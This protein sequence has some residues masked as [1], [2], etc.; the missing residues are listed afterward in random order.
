MASGLGDTSVPPSLQ[1][2]F[3][4]S[5]SFGNHMDMQGV[6]GATSNQFTA[7]QSANVR[8]APFEF[9][10]SAATVQNNLDPPGSDTSWGI[11]AVNSAHP[12]TRSASR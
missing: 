7:V 12:L 9:D 2:G 4:F 6:G 8:T 5:S 11:L 1:F 3:D 10:A